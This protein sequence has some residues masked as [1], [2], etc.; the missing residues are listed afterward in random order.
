MVKIGLTGG[1]ATGKSTVGKLLRQKGVVVVSSDELSHQEMSPDGAAYHR[2][3]TEFGPEI[4]T[5][6][7]KIDRRIL[8]GIVFKDEVARRKLEQIVHPLVIKGIRDSFEHY[9][10][11]GVPIVVV[12]VPLLFEVGWMDLFDQIWVVTSSLERQLQRISKRDGLTEEEAK[13]RIA[14]QLP[15]EKK[16]EQAD[17]IIK[18]NNGLDSLEKQVSILLRTLE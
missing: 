3:L 17:V 6:D 9:S 15:L 14:S 12:E 1:I 13:K 18:N 2:I 7:G 16:E 8:G 5:A 4:L 10:K 11:L